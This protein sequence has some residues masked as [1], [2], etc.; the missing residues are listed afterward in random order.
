MAFAA[1]GVHWLS[2]ALENA[3]NIHPAIALKSATE[4]RAPAQIIT[5]TKL[6]EIDSQDVNP[7]SVCLK[8]DLPR[9]I[10]EN[11][12]ANLEA[13]EFL[14]ALNDRLLEANQRQ[15]DQIDAVTEC[16]ENES[17]CS[18]PKAKQTL[19]LFKKQMELLPEMRLHLA[20][21]SV[22]TQALKYRNR[23]A[24]KP[25]PTQQRAKADFGISSE[26][27]SEAQSNRTLR[28][29]LPFEADLAHKVPGLP[30]LEPLSNEELSRVSQI[31]NKDV[32][33]IMKGYA[34]A[35]SGNIQSSA[36]G[37]PSHSNKMN[38]DR[39]LSAYLRKN[40]E[41]MAKFYS[42]QY[43]ARLMRS[44][45]LAYYS[46]FGYQPEQ[47]KMAINRFRQNISSFRGRSLYPNYSKGNPATVH[48]RSLDGLISLEGDVNAYLGQPPQQKYCQLAH[49]IHKTVKKNSA[50]KGAAKSWGLFAF[51]VGCFIATNGLAAPLCLAPGL[52][53]GAGNVAFQYLSISD[54]EMNAFR[55]IKGSDP[56]AIKQ[57]SIQRRNFQISLGLY[58]F[59]VGVSAGIFQSVGG[60]LSDQMARIISSEAYAIE[61]IGSSLVARLGDQVQSDLVRFA[62][63]LEQVEAATYEGKI[64]FYHQSL[65]LIRSSLEKSRRK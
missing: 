56:R 28:H 13:S 47:L 51:T 10:G 23:W 1:G 8:K 11:G 18:N 48:W 32:A 7:F 6:L 29:L 61:V 63:A 53:Y 27:F 42:S 39:E 65:S 37:L 22:D 33:E 15:I 64:H 19:A 35:Q 2:G 49:R 31:F 40:F 12:P 57:I 16:L 60:V 30:S 14:L 38:R 54:E 20:L 50:N 34:Q 52:A 25:M 17:R 43:S 21:A 46:G 41:N 5:H 4:T 62:L 3:L 55:N 26:F 44:P 58:L 24:V 36:Q 9:Q 59:S 45:I